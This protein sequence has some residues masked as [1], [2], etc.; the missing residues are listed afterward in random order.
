MVCFGSFSAVTARPF[1]ALQGSRRA[2]RRGAWGIP[3]GG[4][5]R[6]RGGRFIREGLG[7]VERGIFVH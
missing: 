7:V 2:I 6:H 3:C 4:R 1:G 5:L